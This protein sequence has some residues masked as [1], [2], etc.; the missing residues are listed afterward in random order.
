MSMSCT[1]TAINSHRLSCIFKSNKF[2]IIFL[3]RL[4]M[5]KYTVY[6]EI[7]VPQNFRKFLIFCFATKNNFGRVSPCHTFFLSMW[8]IHKIF[9][10][11]F[12][13]I[14]QHRNFLVYGNSCPYLC[15][16]IMSANPVN[17]A[18]NNLQKISSNNSMSVC[19]DDQQ[20]GDI[21]NSISILII[22][23]HCSGP[24]RRLRL[25]W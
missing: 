18:K 17:Y 21:I 16:K 5:M 9:E 20:Y 23:T 1:V 6:Q 4:T 10:I 22:M 13:K 15:Y 7:F 25:L 14:W 19:L 11:V 2:C 3:W 24:A 12:V 8:I